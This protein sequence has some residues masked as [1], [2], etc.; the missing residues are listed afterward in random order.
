MLGLF[1]TD[2]LAD[3]TNWEQLAF[4]ATGAS[5]YALSS[6]ANGT[7][8]V[9]P[10]ALT[11]GTNSMQIVLNASG[12]V[13]FGSLVGGG[14]VNADSSGILGLVTIGSGLTYS[15]GILSASGGG[16]GG[17][18]TSV[19]G[20]APIFITSS[21]T[22]TPNVTIQGAIV[23]GS[24]S[25]SAQDLGGLGQG[26]LQQ[27]VTTGVATISVFTATAHRLAFGSGTAGGFTDSTNLVFSGSQ[28]SINQ[29][30]FDGTMHV[31]LADDTTPASVAA[32]D[33]RHA[34]F[35]QSGSTGGGLGISYG[36]TANSVYLTAAV[37]NVAFSS[38]RVD[39]ETFALYSSGT[40]LGPARREC[41]R[42]RCW[43]GG[44]WTRKSGRV[45]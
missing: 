38:L 12:T 43:P 41:E 18:V 21:P 42:V 27:A 6:L 23:S 30:T 7:G 33:T 8:T 10:V 9:R 34:V 35:G 4:E 28:L 11:T 3:S 40:I 17:T 26:V 37:P 22:T 32:W 19:G 13:T 25:T 2:Y 39:V 31:V 29:S 14:I 15:G 24:T 5:G 45:R 36:S 1:N 20:T 44:W 16:G